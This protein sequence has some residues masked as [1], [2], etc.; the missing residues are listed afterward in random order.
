MLETI[1]KK[2]AY[3]LGDV[4]GVD[5]DDL[6]YTV[7]LTHDEIDRVKEIVEDEHIDIQ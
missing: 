4:C 6:Y 7:G 1:I 3:Y 2:M 5:Y